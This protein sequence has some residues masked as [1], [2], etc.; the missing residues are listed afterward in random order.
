[1][2]CV[3]LAL[4]AEREVPDDEEPAHVWGI[5]DNPLSVL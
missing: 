3:H 2:L 5:D 1:M 4:T